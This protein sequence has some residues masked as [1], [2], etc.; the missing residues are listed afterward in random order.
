MVRSATR[1]SRTYGAIVT[2]AVVCTLIPLFLTAPAYA[3][4]TKAISITDASIV[5][6]DAGPA[7]SVAFTVTWSGSKGGGTVSVHYA[8]ADVTASAGTD[9]TAKSGTLSLSSGGCH[10]ATISVT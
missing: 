2:V 10:C 7:K 6:G 9:Y 5:E 1:L 3:A 4:K 8:T